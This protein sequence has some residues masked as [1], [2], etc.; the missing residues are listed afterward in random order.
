MFPKFIKVTYALL[1]LALGGFFPSSAFARN[2]SVVTASFPEYDLVSHI[3]GNK[4][5]V[6]MLLKPGSDPH[7]FDPSHADINI[8]RKSDL[9]VYTGEENDD[10]VD[11]ILEDYPS[12]NSFAFAGEVPL[13]TEEEIPGMP[14]EKDH[15]DH[16]D[17]DYDEHVF[18][19]PKNDIKLLNALCARIIAL[20]PQNAEYYKKNCADYAAR[21]AE[22]DKAFKQVVAES[23]SKTLIFADRF[24]FRYFCD[25]YGLTYFAAFKDCTDDYKVRRSTISFLADKVRELNKKVILKIELTSSAPAQD[26]AEKAGGVKIA[27]MNAGHNVTAEQLDAHVSLADLYQNNLKVLKEALN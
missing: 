2:L 19:S 16:D 20:D 5:T 18:T 3:T 25:D 6:R 7:S 11:D 27:V 9:F 14:K 13:L 1:V 17:V 23:K 15:D 8:I 4:A 26:V 22:L 10:W 21:F 24:A 12:I